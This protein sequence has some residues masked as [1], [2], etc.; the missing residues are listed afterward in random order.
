MR[1]DWQSATARERRGQRRA[2]ER[3]AQL[4]SPSPRESAPATGSQLALI[5]H[6]AECK[7]RPA[8]AVTSRR[9]ASAVITQLK[10]IRPKT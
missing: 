10:L 7:G 9:E 6:L 2:E 5:T 3:A 4:T 1:L 8:P